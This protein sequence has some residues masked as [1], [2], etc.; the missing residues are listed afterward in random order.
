MAPQSAAIFDLDRTLIADSS[1]PV[2]AKY[3]TEAGVMDGPPIPFADLLRRAFGLFGE[4]RLLMEPARRAVSAVRGWSPAAVEEA[5]RLAAKELVGHVQPFAHEIIE[6][7]R[8]AGR[9]LVLATTSPEP[10]VQPFAEQLG[11]DDVVATQWERSD[12][13]GVHRARS[14]GRSSGARRRPMPSPGGPRDNNVASIGVGRTATATS[15]H[16]CSMVG[17][18]VAVNPDVQLRSTRH[19]PGLAGPPLRQ[20]DGVIK[21]AG[22]ELQEWDRPSMRPE[23]VAPNARHRVRRRREHPADRSGDPGVQPPLVLRPDRD[24]A[25]D[26]QGRTQR[27]RPRQEGGVRRPDRRSADDGLGRDPGR[28]GTGSDE[29][30]EAATPR[31]RP[32]SS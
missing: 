19:D 25:A 6:E 21:I 14:T 2:F 12:E 5:C 27:P 4:S 8:A 31:R 24:G 32:A 26:R 18:P 13:D 20:T 1:T 7:H 11:F 28:A 23:I 9:L 29:P 22:R 17:H 16:R 3:L 30:L 10:F 15:T